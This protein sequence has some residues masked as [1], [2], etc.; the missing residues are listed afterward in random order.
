MYTA[1][2][3]FIEAL[4]DAGVSYIFANFGSDHPGLIEALAQAQAT[5]QPTPKVITC[6]N[7]FVA[8]TCAQGYTQYTGRA[9]AVVVHVECGTQSLAGAVHNVSRC[10]VP[11]LIYAVASPYTQESELRGTRSEFIHWLQDVFDQRGIVRPYMKYDNELRT[12]RNL[13]Q[14]VHR[15]LQFAYSD[16]QGPAYL[17]A[18]REVMEEE[19]PRIDVDPGRFAAIEPAALP[20][21]GV[22]EIA[23]ELRSAKRPLA[24]TTYL[25]RNPAAVDELVRLAR[26]TG[27]GV[28]ESVPTYL[29]F[30]SDHPLLVASQGNEPV[31]NRALEEADFVLVLDSDVPWIPKVNQPNPQARIYHIDVDPIKQNMP[32]WYIPAKRVFR[33][34]SATALRQ[35]HD[36]LGSGVDAALVAERTA[37]YTRMHDERE[38]RLAAA[39]QLP[40]ETITAEYL[41]ACVRDHID[42]DTVVLN[43]GITNYM[44]IN[45]HIRR[46]RPKTRF[47]SGASSLGWNGGAAVGIK[48]AAPEKTVLSL[49]GDGSYMFSQPST[50]HW[51][52]KRYAAPFLHVVYN[53]RGWRAPKISALSVHPTGYASKSGDIGV[54]FDPPPDYARIAAAAGGAFAKTVKRPD[55]LGPAIEEA[56]H[57]VRVEGRSAVLDV[58]LEH[59]MG[60]GR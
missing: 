31:Q 14:M 41:T 54:A 17:M 15:A 48:L 28:V 52:A 58:W 22:E 16:P 27:M 13:K 23:Q 43:E 53:N 24:V 46:T 34:D 60:P 45:D 40:G 59:L 7:E 51:I 12:G 39:E 3:A 36:R 26:C 29:N 38:T 5:G 47:T 57:A 8:L 32:L 9:Q 50:V 30:P 4:N 49:T 1:S 35:I 42:A 56:L 33:A 55:E 44:A 10:R 2:S 6:P 19:V 37:H 18:P 25:G 20:P 11:V 21:S